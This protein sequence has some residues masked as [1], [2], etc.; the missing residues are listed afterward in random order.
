MPIQKVGIKG[1]RYP[2]A[3]RT[4][5]GGVQHTVAEFT[6]SVGLPHDVK[7]THMSRFVEVLEGFGAPLDL[8]GL[9]TLGRAMLARLSA[10]IGP[11]RDRVSRTSSASTRRC[12]ASRACS[13]TRRASGSGWTP[14][15]ARG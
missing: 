1:L 5:S 12:P 9:R 3:L 6:M 8:A 13:T 11:P 4:A 2:I 7:G 10:A 14:T 15:G